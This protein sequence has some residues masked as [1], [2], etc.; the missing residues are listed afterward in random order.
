MF[1]QQEVQILI[2]GVDSPIDLDDLQ[3]NTN[4]GG[5]Y[6]EKHETIIAF[7]KVY[8]VSV[9]ISTLLFVWPC[10]FRLSTL[11][12]R[13]RKGL[14]CDS[15]QVVVD[16]LFCLFV[17]LAFEFK[18][19]DL[20]TYYSGFK[21]LVPNFCIRD[22]G[23]DQYRLPTSST[24]V[25]LLKVSSITMEYECISSSSISSF[26]YTQVTEHY[27]SSCCRRSIRGLDST[28]LEPFFSRCK[29]RCMVDLGDIL[30]L[31]IVQLDVVKSTVHS[32]I[33][34]LLAITTGHTV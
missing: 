6:D 34:L 32:S 26:Q 1:N 31:N 5:L 12:T 13:S 20:V 24:C 22:A 27:V 9:S 7:W 28:C 33:V 19:A 21:E 23:T 29:F 8:P 18:T 14:Y 17:F 2:G 15:L 10:Y 3:R 4:Y 11:S 30:T 25:N 16:P